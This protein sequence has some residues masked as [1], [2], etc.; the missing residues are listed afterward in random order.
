MR[1]NTHWPYKPGCQFV[2]LF[3]AEIKAAVEDVKIPVEQIMA[4]T[5]Y[6]LSIPLKI[7]DSAIPCEL[8]EVNKEFYLAMFSLQGPKGFSFG[9]T[10]SI[11]LRIIQELEDVEV[12]TRV[13]QII[14]GNPHGGYDFEEMVAAYKDTG[15][16]TKKALE[17]IDQKRQK[18]AQEATQVNQIEETTKK[19][20]DMHNDDIHA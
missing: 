9:E 6:T 19:D 2:S 15:Y 20:D 8:T 7:K 10:V 13:M 5:N 18:K 1:N 17:M 14:E 3:S 11:K 4:M 16:D 12:Y